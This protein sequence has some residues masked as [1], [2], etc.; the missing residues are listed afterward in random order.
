MDGDMAQV[1]D[2]AHT[3]L[4]STLESVVVDYLKPLDTGYHFHVLPHTYYNAGPLADAL[5][6]G[7]RLRDVLISEGYDAVLASYLYGVGGTPPEVLIPLEGT[8]THIRIRY[9]HRSIKDGTPFYNLHA[10][11]DIMMYGWGGHKYDIASLLDYIPTMISWVRQ[12]MQCCSCHYA[13]DGG[14]VCGL[15]L[16]G[17]GSCSQ[18]MQV[19]APWG[20]DYNYYLNRVKYQQTQ[21][22]RVGCT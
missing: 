7:I 9:C 11:H 18:Y 8:D 10:Y 6:F 21:E 12:R 17:D 1:I 16:V 22:M 19:S 13:T 5:A 2:T 14:H 15:G 4:A 3:D 20:H